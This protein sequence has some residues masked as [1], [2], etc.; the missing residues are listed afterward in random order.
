MDINKLNLNEYDLIKIENVSH[1]KSP[2][3]ETLFDITVEGDHTF[4]IKLPNS[5]DYILAHNCDGAH[6]TS[7]FLGWFKRFGE[8]LF[9]ENKICKLNIP[10]VLIV[11]KHEKVIDHFFNLADFNEW[12][13]KHQNHKYKIEYW[14][15]LGSISKS[16]LN[17]LIDKY[18]LDYFIETYK[19]DEDGQIYLNNWLSDQTVSERKEYLKQHQLDINNI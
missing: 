11:D 16:L 18:G 13:N 19:L 5:E 15:G 17:Q 4:F 10:L 7:M 6:L 14:K 8:N 3:E 2:I 1:I 12:E 9:H